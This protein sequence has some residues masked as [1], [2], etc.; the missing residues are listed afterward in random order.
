MKQEKINRAEADK[1]EEENFSI[2]YVFGRCS[3]DLE[4]RKAFQYCMPSIDVTG[5]AEERK[6]FQFYA[7]K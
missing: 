6:D 4:E 1:S 2:L 5:T 7:F 3:R